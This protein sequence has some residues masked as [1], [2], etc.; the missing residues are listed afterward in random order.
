MA[1]VAM[2]Y[3]SSLFSLSALMASFL[4]EIIGAERMGNFASGVPCSGVKLSVV[5]V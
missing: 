2:L 1:I 5:M 4:V 3:V